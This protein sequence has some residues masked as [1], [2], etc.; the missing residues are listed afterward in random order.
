MTCL[1]CGATKDSGTKYCNQACQ[2]EF[3]YK[4]RIRKWLAGEING[5]R[6]KT[7]TAQWIKRYV[8]ETRGHNCE[9]CGNTEWKGQ[10]ILLELEH[11]DGDFGNNKIE[12]L[13]LLC[14][15]CHGMTPT[16]RSKNRMGR[17][18]EKYYRKVMEG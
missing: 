14:L 15:N 9:D 1:N 17:P 2:Q 12:N 6:G 4:E 5:K 10:P 18:R 11:V 7:A 13:K 3:Q 16:Y 8:I